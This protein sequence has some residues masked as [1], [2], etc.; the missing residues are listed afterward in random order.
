MTPKWRWAEKP[1]LSSHRR[2][3]WL[4]P[5]HFTKSQAREAN[6]V[7]LYW[8]PLGPPTQTAPLLTVLEMALFPAWGS[9]KVR[10]KAGQE[11]QDHAAL[12]QRER[13]LR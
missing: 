1:Q 6:V 7:S 8:L 9:V 11:K 12:H 2:S 5:F 13:C 4:F 10:N 3:K